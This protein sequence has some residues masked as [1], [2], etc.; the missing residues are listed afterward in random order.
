MLMVP[1]VVGKQVLGVAVVTNYAQNAFTENDLRLLQTL[2]ANMGVAIQNARLFE[3]EQQRVAEL[4]IINS[5]QQG[6]AAELNF[7]A[8]VDLVGD[9]LRQVLNT[10]DLGIAW[11]DEKANLV[12]SLYDYEHG[13]R[14]T[15]A[16][17][18]APRPDGVHARLTKTRQ[19]LV[20][21]TAAEGDAIS[22]T[23]PGTDT[24][25]S[26]VFLPIIS[27]DRM[28]GSIR[29]ENYERENAF[30]ESELR[31]LTTVAGS[32]GAAL[33]NARLFDET[34]RLL[35]AEQERVAELQI[36][37]SI[38]QGLAAELDF[39][40][41]VDLVGD[42]L[43]AVF[44]I[45]DLFINWYD[46]KTNLVNFL[47][48]YE[49]GQ[50]LIIAPQPHRP[51]SIVARILRDRQPVVWNTVAEG[52]TLAPA[53]P[54][55][56]P[57]KSGVSVPIISGD[58]VLGVIQMENYER[59][60]AYG[61]AELRLLTTIAA[62]LGSSLEN[63]RLFNETQRLLKETEQRN[64]E[65]AIINSIQQGLAAELNFQAIIDLVGDKL[66]QV[67]TNG[68]IGMRWHD[69]QANLIPFSV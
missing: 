18:M 15:S 22:P 51:N 39:Q 46:E 4:Q 66:R 44:N 45:P 56:D 34:Q 52:D 36:I 28:L 33:E 35:K 11:Y 27:S 53:I 41:I 67:F 14:I 63:A 29:V 23:V 48:S 20:Y 58:R 25:K 9:K 30:G 50:R 38:Q 68:D 40:A 19:P 3:A 42:K 64:A 6:L 32:L 7:Q 24:S 8:I 12:H 16:P 43:R 21:G 10:G 31:L 5:I 69:P 59:E 55:T 54:G 62:S 26:G 2:S 13:K 57:S 49:H 65:L 60:N 37:N 61:E 17:P 1:I 47:Y